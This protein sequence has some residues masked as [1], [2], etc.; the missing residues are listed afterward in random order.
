MASPTNIGGWSKS[1]G[2]PYI[3]VGATSKPMNTLREK[4]SFETR[5]HKERRCA[6]R[7]STSSR[8]AL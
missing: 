4:G 5:P 8:L 3:F 6:D 1:T 2:A 7:A